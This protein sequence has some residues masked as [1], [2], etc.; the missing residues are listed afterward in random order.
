MRK[1]GT[2]RGFTI[3]EIM[4]VVA[5]LGI[6]A[7]L[8]LPSIKVNAIRTKMAEVILAFGPCKAMVTEIYLSGDDPPAA[9]TWGC[10]IGPNATTYVDS[11]TTTSEGVIKVS[12]HGF[13]DGRFDSHT[14]TLA[15]LDN[16]GTLLST[17]G[18]AVARWRCGSPVDATDVLPQYLPASC[19]GG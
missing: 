15:P 5:I 3:V 6:L 12:L 13:N 2:Q 19:R 17:G 11:V 1:Y 9:G 8:V 16:T 7:V 4:G 10:E 14:L 18:S